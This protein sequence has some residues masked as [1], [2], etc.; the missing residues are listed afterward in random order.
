MQI[1]NTASGRSKFLNKTQTT[2]SSGDIMTKIFIYLSVPLCSEQPACHQCV[3]LHWDHFISLSKYNQP[4]L[5]LSQQLWV[6]QSSLPTV[7]TVKRLHETVTLI[8]LPASAPHA[9]CKQGSTERWATSCTMNW[10]CHIPFAHSWQT[11]ARLTEGLPS[12]SFWLG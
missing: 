1:N 10:H 5:D 11:A 4:R 6:H 12:P 3:W 8:F 9:A 7:K 2:F